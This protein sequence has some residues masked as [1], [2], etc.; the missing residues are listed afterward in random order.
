MSLVQIAALAVL[1]VLIGQLSKARQL[2]LLAVSTAVLFW[3]Q[4]HQPLPTLGFWLP[5]G[6]LGLT[7]MSWVLTSESEARAWRQTWPAAAVIVA[8][9]VLVEINRFAG[10]PLNAAMR[11]PAPSQAL[12]GALAVAGLVS[13]WWRRKAGS[14]FL[15]A[16]L[17]GV[18]VLAFIVL[19]V[20]GIAEATAAWL[21]ELPLAGED[22]A[23]DV[24]FSWL[25]FSYVAFRL[26][27]TVRDRQ[28]GRLPAVSL[29]EYVNYVIFFPA[30]TAGP[31]DRVQRFVKDLRSPLQLQNDDW[32]DAGR[33]LVVGLFKKFVVADLLAVISVSD[34]L[35]EHVQAAGWMWLFVYAYALR[36]Y[37]DFSG[38]TDMA[39]GM[40]RLL[41]VRL[42]E[43]FDS[44]YL[45]ENI[46]LFWNSW[47]MSLTQW[48]RS[49][50]FN[51]LT[52]QLRSGRW[53][54]PTWIAILITQLVTMLLIGLWHGIT[55]G[56][57]VWG[58][59]HGLGLFAH[60]RWTE[61]ARVRW[62]AGIQTAGARRVAGVLGAILTFHFV[63]VGWLF[64]CLSTPAVAWKAVLVL[65]G[66]A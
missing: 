65:V 44:P 41:G 38:Y 11:A 59:W 55:W 14:P 51:P 10:P 19:K 61:F 57:A 6:T 42:P 15:L 31:I 8:V 2:S 36:I 64:F 1:A 13:I 27:H 23:A 24:P 40:G 66:A 46:A 39:I 49:Y 37:F 35:V 32:L 34:L 43:N 60:N 26:L 45:K 54:P 48:F 21:Q 9:V 50:V 18:I 17:S 33:R 16:A 28:A 4:P 63:A 52:R 25:G 12:L 22:I 20:P 29:S 30:F 5:F 7:I 56:F 53:A 58:L 62:P 47:H 3:L